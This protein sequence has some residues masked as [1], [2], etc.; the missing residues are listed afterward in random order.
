MID[1]RERGG[2]PRQLHSSL[3]FA[4][5]A[6]NAWLRGL[7]LPVVALHYRYEPITALGL[8]RR[9]VYQYGLVNVDLWVPAHVLDAATSASLPLQKI[10]RLT[11]V[12]L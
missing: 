9:L 1:R 5:A 10:S 12:R 4:A 8:I 11:V 6:A 2:V 3:I 7:P